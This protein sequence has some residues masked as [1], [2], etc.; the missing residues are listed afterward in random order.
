MSQAAPLLLLRLPPFETDRLFIYKYYSPGQDEQ[1]QARL[2]QSV[3]WNGMQAYRSNQIRII[4]N[5]IGMS[6]TPIGQSRSLDELLE[7]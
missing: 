6:W 1:V 3:S 4:G 7:L 5:W 2:Q